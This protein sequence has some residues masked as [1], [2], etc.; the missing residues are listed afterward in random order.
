MAA[1]MLL[2]FVMMHPGIT[3]SCK[4]NCKQK[5]ECTSIHVGLGKKL[6]VNNS[7]WGA[8]GN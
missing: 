7:N 1:F 5:V 3:S 4:K 2:I 6:H 8:H